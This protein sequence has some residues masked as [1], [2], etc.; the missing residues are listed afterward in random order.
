MSGSANRRQAVLLLGPT[1]SGKTPLGELLERRGYGGRK[2]L[3]FDFGANLRSIVAAGK[4][5]SEITA[6]DIDFLR[7]VLHEGALLEDGHFHLARSV[8]N[9][10]LASRAD[11]AVRPPDRP[12]I[13]VLNGLPRHVGQAAS[14]DGIVEVLSVIYLRCDAA[15]VSARISGNVGGDR[16]GRIDDGLAAIR[17]KLSIFSDR[18]RPLLDYYRA[19]GVDVETVD[20]GVETTPQDVFRHITGGVP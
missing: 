5:S 13:I 8:Y 12:A 16:A 14:V 15:G 18:T 9:A 2:C 6:D 17:N 11:E 10:F 1:G 20:V 4:P 3:H 7:R 19:R